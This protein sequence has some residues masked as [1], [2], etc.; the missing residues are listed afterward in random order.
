MIATIPYNDDPFP[1]RIRWT[2]ADCTKLESLEFLV[3][4][5]YE[6]VEGEIVL[7]VGQNEPHVVANMKAL[8]A[9]SL[10]FGQEHVRHSSPL[11]FGPNDNPEPDVAVTVLPRPEYLLRGTP[12][13]ADVLLIV[14]I[15]DATLRYDR[16]TKAALYARAG[17]A[18]YWIVDLNGRRL[19]VHRNPTALGYA[20]VQEL[21]EQDAVSP[22][23]RSGASTSVADLLP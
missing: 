21:T 13:D 1:H 10:I 11:S 18:E 19:I 4:G 17:I 6:L 23:S 20:N 12:T 16:H 5:K 15:S 14:E 3:P 7:K 22:L 8:F 9:L 2:R